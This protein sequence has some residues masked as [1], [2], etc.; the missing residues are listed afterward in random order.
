MYPV[1]EQVSFIVH[2]VFAYKRN[3][4]NFFLLTSKCTAEKGVYY[5]PTV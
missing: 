1:T 5:V 2:G 3:K 4:V